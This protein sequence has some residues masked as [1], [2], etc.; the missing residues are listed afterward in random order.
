MS[1]ALPD[2]L[3][4]LLARWKPASLL[5]I[6]DEAPGDLVPG[7]EVT[8]IPAVTGPGGLDAL[9]RFDTA[10]L[11]AGPGLEAR[12]LELLLGRLKNVHAPKVAAVLGQAD[13]D[14]LRALAF[15]AAG[16]GLWVHDIDRYNPRR[17]WNCADDWA[18]PEN[19]H[20]DRW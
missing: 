3:L 18:H 15:E 12:T 13:P 17:E 10:V 6:A 9:G 8:R 5:L 4:D 7:A 14:R 19:F 20:K 11:L 1:P 2:G 16:D